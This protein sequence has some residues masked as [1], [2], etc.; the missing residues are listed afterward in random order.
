MIFIYYFPWHPKDTHCV[1]WGKNEKYKQVFQNVKYLKEWTL[2]FLK[3]FLFVEEKIWA[4]KC[5]P[6]TLQKSYQVFQQNGQISEIYTRKTKKS[7]IFP[8]FCQRTDK[9]SPK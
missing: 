8:I 7:N 2:H 6:T 9:I 1:S 3:H 4:I 5:L